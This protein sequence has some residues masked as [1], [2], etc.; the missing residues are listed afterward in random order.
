M[1][2]KRK[3]ISNYFLKYVSLKKIYI[4]G[5]I[6]FFIF[7][8]VLF[9]VT[10][11]DTKIVTL[12][13]KSLPNTIL[14]SSRFLFCLIYLH[15]LHLFFPEIITKHYHKKRLQGIL[16]E[17]TP[18]NHGTLSSIFTYCLISLMFSNNYCSYLVLDDFVI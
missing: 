6:D 7:C 14:S 11:H 2:Y 12:S 15:C 9:T 10:K 3:N 17:F 18:Y 16:W 13:Y 4:K 5:K 8:F 1:Q